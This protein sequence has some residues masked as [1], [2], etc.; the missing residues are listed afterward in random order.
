MCSFM[1]LCTRL[2]PWCQAAMGRVCTRLAPW[3]LAAMESML[4][5]GHPDWGTELSSLIP[6]GNTAGKGF[7]G[8]EEREPSATKS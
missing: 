5:G 8:Q 4:K 3:C 1:L 6:Q 2:A 7:L